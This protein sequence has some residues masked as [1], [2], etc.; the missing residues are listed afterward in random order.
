MTYREWLHCFSKNLGEMM[1]EARID[2]KDLA[3][4]S[5]LSKAAISRYIHE[6][7][8][9]TLRSIINIAYALHVDYEDLID[10]GEPI[11]SEE[12]EKVDSR[13]TH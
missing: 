9:P 13:F 6:A 4:M 12:C 11:D 2:C 5:G 8:M 1:Y 10:F 3:E 7:Q